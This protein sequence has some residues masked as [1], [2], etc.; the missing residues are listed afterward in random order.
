VLANRGT[1]EIG[2]NGTHIAPVLPECAHGIDQIV[3]LREVLPPWAQL[4]RHGCRSLKKL[5]ASSE[6]SFY[7]A[8]L[9]HAR[10]MGIRQAVRLHPPH[11]AG[12]G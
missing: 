6:G 5:Q 4:E 2:R 12:R 7:K 11:A 1:P 9:G 3:R 8:V 10:T